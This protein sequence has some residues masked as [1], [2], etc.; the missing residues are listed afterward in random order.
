MSGLGVKPRSLRLRLLVSLVGALVG[1]VLVFGV[2]T[3]RNVLAAAQELF[4]YQLR[5]MALTLREQGS[6][7]GAQAQALNDEGL[8]FVVQIWT[9]DGRTVF[10]SR[11]HDVLPSRA[12]LGFADV[13]VPGSIWRT[14]TVVTADL[15]IQV[16]QPL[17]V[18]ETLAASAAL[19]SVAPLLVLVPVIA[20]IVWWLVAASLRPLQRVAREVRARDANAL[21]PV[22]G[23]GVPDEVEPLVQS[24][25]ALLARLSASFDAQRAFV[26]DAAHELRS[27]LTALKLQLE[28]LRRAP[29]GE[30][31]AAAV[32]SLSDGIERASRLVDQL[33]ELARSE[34]AGGPSVLRRVVPV[35]LGEVARQTLAAL[36]PFAH[37]RATTLVL[38]AEEKVTVQGDAGAL[39]VLVRNLVDNAVRYSPRGAEVLV[40]VAAQYGRSE[41]TVD[42]SGPGIPPEERE[43]VLDRFYRRSPSVSDEG[44]TG[45]GLAIVRNIALQHGARLQ[46]AESPR[47][48]LRVSVE[49]KPLSPSPA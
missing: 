17:Q 45:L 44:G 18:R 25:N 33:L 14:Y 26:A 12:V 46:L 20:L 34:S 29:D 24:L 10:A 43:R 36:G 28:L 49:F 16:A 19:R 7:V 11:R 35:D 32:T 8:D 47:G 41:L 38:E 22:S 31:R 6:L 27:P 15:V 2:L 1:A 23:E 5:Q 13:K 42:D 39:A 21:S 48:G 3:Y 30:A 37:S 40:R 4:D 9:T